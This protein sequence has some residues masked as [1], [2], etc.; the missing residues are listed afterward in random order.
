[1]YD[2][3][4][5]GK[6]KLAAIQSLV[7]RGKRVEAI[8]LA[9]ETENF[10][11]ALLIASHCGPETYQNTVQQ[12]TEK[13]FRNGSPLH[14]LGVL[15]SG[16][17]LDAS[18]PTVDSKDLLAS[19]RHHL[20]AII[21]NRTIGWERA[22]YTLG[23]KL[24]QAGSIHASHFCFLVCGLQ[25]MSPIK[26]EAYVSMLGCD[27]LLPENV[28]LMTKTGIDAYG[29]TEAYEWA[30]RRGNPSALIKALQ[31]FK[32]QYAM[33]LADLGFIDLAKKYLENIFA[34]CQLDRSDI[35]FVTSTSRLTVPEMCESAEAFAAALVTFE[36]RLY[37]IA[38]DAS[39]E[40]R[41]DFEEVKQEPLSPQFQSPIPPM[42]PSENGDILAAPSHESDMSFMTAATSLQPSASQ[43]KPKT[44]NRVSTKANGNK[45]ARVKRKEKKA[46]KIN[47]EETKETTNGALAAAA[48]VP[49]PMSE[50]Y[51]AHPTSAPPSQLKS[52][53]DEKPGAMATPGDLGKTSSKPS[54]GSKPSGKTTETKKKPKDAPKS[55][56]AAIQ[57]KCFG[58]F[59]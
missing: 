36:Q 51:S 4:E 52:P 58:S 15:F 26:P 38:P 49:P 40:K 7:L 32:L 45:L 6:T 28:S 20:A 22:I 43:P 55:A 14:T 29:R 11:L 47:E 34:C 54:T 46:E 24:L 3:G 48:F 2:V 33:I 42:S 39:P 59:R 13:A 56:P 5:N 1:M 9:M 19:W 41:L 25:V 17:Q 53:P 31:P 16:Q 57:S 50:P 27:H 21:S 10:A 37:Q 12:Y 44:K 8:E 30:K 23:S 35:R 18:L